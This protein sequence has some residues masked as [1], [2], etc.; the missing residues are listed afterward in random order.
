M[1][2]AAVAASE[3]RDSTKGSPGTL[4]R[5]F[6]GAKSAMSFSL[7]LASRQGGAIPVQQRI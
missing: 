2:H 5:T 4:C 6:F 3:P 1:Y 7:Q